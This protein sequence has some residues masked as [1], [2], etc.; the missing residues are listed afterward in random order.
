[1]T[2]TALQ[3]TATTFLAF[4]NSITWGENGRPPATARFEPIQ[5]EPNAYPTQ[6]EAM[7]RA[8]FPAQSITVINKGKPGEQV[9]DPEQEQRLIDALQ[10][11]R[12]DALLLLEGINDVKAETIPPDSIAAALRDNIETALDRGVRFVFVSTLL[13]GKPG[14][15]EPPEDLVVATNDRIRPMVPPAGAH[16]VDP[17]G[18]FLAQRDAYIDEDGL[19]LTPAGNRALAEAFF[20]SIKSVMATSRGALWARER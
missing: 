18:T 19:H 4:G 9:T 1:V 13:P 20:E 8:A 12:P 10:K 6:L 16:L 5:D 7:L 15:R 11:Y 17:Y 14:R 2:L 3:L